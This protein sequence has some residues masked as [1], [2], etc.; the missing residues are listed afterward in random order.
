MHVQG[1]GK[2]MKTLEILNTFVYEYGIGPPFASIQPQSLE[3][4][5]TSFE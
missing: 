1:V 4:T 3:W 2:I 5:H